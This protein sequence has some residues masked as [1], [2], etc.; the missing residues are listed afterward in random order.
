MTTFLLTFLQ[1]RLVSWIVPQLRKLGYQRLDLGQRCWPKPRAFVPALSVTAGRECGCSSARSADSKAMRLEFRMQRH[2][3]APKPKG[4]W[5][6]QPN[7]D[8]AERLTHFLL[9]SDPPTATKGRTGT[10]S[11]SRCGCQTT[12]V[13]SFLSSSTT[14]AVACH[15]QQREKRPLRTHWRLH[16][17]YSPSRAKAMHNTVPIRNSFYG[18]QRKVLV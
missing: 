15:V 16:T 12:P 3:L 13:L 4:T 5:P 11:G 10:L 2:H 6:S 1:H 7:S 8:Q 9:D 14:R 17:G 18:L